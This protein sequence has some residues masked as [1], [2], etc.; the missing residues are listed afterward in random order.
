[1]LDSQAIEQIF[2]RLHVRYGAKLSGAYQGIDM[3]AVKADWADV[4]DGVRSDSITYAL[5]NLP[6]EWPPTAGQFRD[7]CRHAPE[8]KLAAILPPAN[9]KARATGIEKLRALKIGDHDPR[10]WIVRLIDR[11]ERGEKLNDGQA[12]ALR[13][14]LENLGL[15]DG[16]TDGDE[17][18]TIQLK[19]TAQHLYESRA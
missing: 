14:V 6:I 4:L 19:K 1:M 7:L 3:H 12:M 18:R 11:Q 17:L 8:R 2:G 13:G 15:S 5:V 16:E 9:P 10:A